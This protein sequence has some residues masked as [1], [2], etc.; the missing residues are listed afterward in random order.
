MPFC[1]RH[2][3]TA[4]GLRPILSS[5]LIFPFYSSDSFSHLRA[6]GTLVSHTQYRTSRHLYHAGKSRHLLS[7]AC[8]S[9]YSSANKAYSHS[10]RPPN[11]SKRHILHRPRNALLQEL[12][13]RF[14]TSGYHNRIKSSPPKKNLVPARKPED[15]VA[16]GKYTYQPLQGAQSFRLMSLLPGRGRERLRCELQEESYGDDA[17]YESLPPMMPFI[18]SDEKKRIGVRD[19]R[20]G[21]STYRHSYTISWNSP[22]SPKRQGPPEY[23]ALSYVWGDQV[24]PAFILCHGKELQIT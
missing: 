24:P 14:V 4:L 2:G 18:S 7:H 12:A 11:R 1:R 19:A 13:I 6:F 20:S 21:K 9:G 22:I 23:E 3:F 17:F 16:H 15:T 5:L 10:N 8:S